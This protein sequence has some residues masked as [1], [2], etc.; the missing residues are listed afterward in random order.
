MQKKGNRAVLYRS[1]DGVFGIR[2]PQIDRLISTC[3]NVNNLN[4]FDFLNLS[5]FGS[6]VIANSIDNINK[7]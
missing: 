2:L 5:G 6:Y 1:F 7:K 4:G 3:Q